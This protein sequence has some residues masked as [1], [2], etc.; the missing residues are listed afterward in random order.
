MII[1][2]CSFIDY[3]PLI[4]ILFVHSRITKF[5]GGI[6]PETNNNDED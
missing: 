3:S 1:D 2:K 6:E 4:V 5:D